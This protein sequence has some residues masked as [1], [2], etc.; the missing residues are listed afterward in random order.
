FGDGPDDQL[1][2]ESNGDY[3]RALGHL[4]FAG[5]NNNTENEGPPNNLLNSVWYQPEE[6]FPIDGTPEVSYHTFWIPVNRHYFDDVKLER[7]LNNFLL[8]EAAGHDNSGQANMF[9]DNAAYRAFLYS[10]FDITP[11]DMENAA[12]GLVCPAA[13]DSLHCFE[14]PFRLGW[15]RFFCF[16]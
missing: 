13:E 7:C 8:T 4:H 10:K 6:V 11:I 2:L 3:T 5:F 14:I 15:W 9:V 16:K 1:P 12:V